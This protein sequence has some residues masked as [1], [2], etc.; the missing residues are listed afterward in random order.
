MAG[1]DVIVRAVAVRW[2]DDVSAGWLEVAVTDAR[3][4]EHRI[5]EKVRKISSASIP[6]PSPFPFELWLK[7]EME[8]IDGGDV[9]VRLNH[10]VTTVDGD[11]ELVVA[12]DDV[13]WL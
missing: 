8:S 7:A 3:R 1:V 10:D 4:R 6:S 12:A 11:R 13:V 9:R 2:R 5:V